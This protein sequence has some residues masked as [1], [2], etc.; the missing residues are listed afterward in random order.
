MALKRVRLPKD[1][2]LSNTFTLMDTS[3]D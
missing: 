1:A 2:M 3:E